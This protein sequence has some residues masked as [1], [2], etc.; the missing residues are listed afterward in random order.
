MFCELAPAP[1]LWNEVKFVAVAGST[2]TENEPLD[3][4]LIRTDNEGNAESEGDTPR[5]GARGSIRSMY[6]RTP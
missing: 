3:V 2:I 5:N 4:F 1:R 6:R